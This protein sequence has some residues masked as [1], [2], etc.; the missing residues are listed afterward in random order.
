MKAKGALCEV[1]TNSM[2]CGD[3]KGDLTSLWARVM[4]HDG[5][6]IVQQLKERTRKGGGQDPQKPS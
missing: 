3:E 4:A 1:L 6:R 2:E 5:G